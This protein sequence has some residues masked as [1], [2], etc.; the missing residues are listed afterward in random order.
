MSYLHLLSKL[1]KET[2]SRLFFQVAQAA[3]LSKTELA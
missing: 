1:E 2:A 3:D